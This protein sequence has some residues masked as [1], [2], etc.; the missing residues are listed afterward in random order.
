MI[1]FSL[2]LFVVQMCREDTL[3]AEKTFQLSKNSLVRKIFDLPQ[4]LI[5]QVK[6]Y[7]LVYY[8]SCTI[9]SGLKIG[10]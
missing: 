4:M 9:F 5:S 8:S 10:T 7:Y 3:L 1:M 6:S 2:G